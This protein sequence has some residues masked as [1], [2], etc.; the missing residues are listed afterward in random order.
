VLSAGAE[1]RPALERLCERYWAPA[2]VFVRKVGHDREGALELVQEFFASVIEGNA[3]ELASAAPGPFRVWLLEALRRFLASRDGAAVDARAGRFDRAGRNLEEVE[4][5]ERAAD[6]K[7]EPESEYVR[8]LALG[9]IERALGRLERDQVE[10]GHAERFAKLRPW[11]GSGHAN[12][13]LNELG[14]ALG[15]GLQST[16][17]AL[18]ALRQ[19]LGSLVRY[20]VENLLETR[21]DVDALQAELDT[22][23]GAL[24]DAPR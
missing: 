8:V 13:N 23:L 24:A 17:I 15:L 12:E 20:E 19:R 2:Y 22:L 5:I 1:C 4:A 10:R 7:R 6:P 18:Y 21:D 3:L 16:K 11:L 9:V 14:A